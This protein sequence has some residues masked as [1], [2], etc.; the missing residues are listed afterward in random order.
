MCPMSGTL[1]GFAST[2]VLI[3]LEWT[4][5]CQ[6]EMPTEMLVDGNACL[7]VCKQKAL[8]I[9]LRRIVMMKSCTRNDWTGRNYYPY[10]HVYT[11]ILVARTVSPVVSAKHL[12]LKTP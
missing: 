11:I 6:A 12:C 5:G 4:L 8:L 2:L 1:A 7:P 3:G 10:T 9:W